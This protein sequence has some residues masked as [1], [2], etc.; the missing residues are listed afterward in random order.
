MLSLKV[1]L[2]KISESEIKLIVNALKNGQVLVL[3]T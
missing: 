2:K 1:N 3:P